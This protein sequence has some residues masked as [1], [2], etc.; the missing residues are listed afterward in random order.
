M[1]VSVKKVRM[2]RKE[3]EDRPGALAATLEP[4]AAAGADLQVVVGRGPAVAPGAGQAA[5]AVY[6]VTGRKAI[7]AAQQAGLSAWAIPALLVEGD[8]RPGLGHAI[9]QALSEA[10]INLAYVMAQVVGR[11]YAAVLGFES[12]ADAARAAA[13][14][15]KASA[16]APRKATPR[17]R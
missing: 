12:D 15:K 9:A 3:V 6:P 10:Q 14:I 11:R 5:I 7:A 4:L 1:A 8:N 17:R 2:W 13:L 16:P